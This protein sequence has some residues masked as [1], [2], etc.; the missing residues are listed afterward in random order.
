MGVSQ[1]VIGR[2][3]LRRKGMGSRREGADPALFADRS[4]FAER[5]IGSEI[6]C[7]KSDLV[8]CRFADLPTPRGCVCQEVGLKARGSA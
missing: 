1:V 3:L 7:S 6:D 2:G 5:V 4:A 8:G